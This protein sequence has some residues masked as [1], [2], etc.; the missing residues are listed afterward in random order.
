[1]E[2]AELLSRIPSYLKSV[3]SSNRQDE[4]FHLSLFF[5]GQA[6]LG[7]GSKFYLRFWVCF[8]TNKA[9]ALKSKLIKFQEQY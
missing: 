4:D 3:F 8:F 7:V 2:H 9:E 1:M 5:Q 6:S